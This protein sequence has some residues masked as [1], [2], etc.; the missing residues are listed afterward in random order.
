MERI[1]NRPEYHDV[2]ANSLS[3]II[4]LLSSGN[5]AEA[6][7][8]IRFNIRQA[9]IIY[10]LDDEENRKEIM[11]KLQE[12]RKSNNKADIDKILTVELEEM[13]LDK[14]K[15]EELLNK[16]FAYQTLAGIKPV[17][18]FKGNARTFARSRG[19]LGF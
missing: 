4:R 10:R 18:S 7:T 8:L 5:M 6:K 2:V 15:D 19:E 12:E 17:Q 9:Y 14:L 11:L 16:M 3:S 1:D 13:K